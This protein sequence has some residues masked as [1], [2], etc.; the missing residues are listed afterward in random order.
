MSRINGEKARSAIEK[1]NRTA[2]REKTRATLAAIRSD[3]AAKA[4]AATPAADG[5]PAAKKSAKSKPAESKPAE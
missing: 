4:T 5:K 3:N 1:R 2:R